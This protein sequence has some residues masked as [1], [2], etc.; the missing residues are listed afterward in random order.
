MVAEAEQSPA[1]ALMAHACNFLSLRQSEGDIDNGANCRGPYAGAG[2][3][4][5]LP[6]T[7]C[8]RIHDPGPSS[9]I[10][11]RNSTHL[12]I[13]RNLPGL[14]HPS[15]RA[16]LRTGEPSD[17]ACL[18]R[19]RSEAIERYL[20]WSKTSASNGF[21]GNHQRKESGRLLLRNRNQ[22]QQQAFCQKAASSFAER[23]GAVNL[24]KVVSG[25]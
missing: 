22:P 14:L 12:L 9:L 3:N 25:R 1:T 13:G 8:T 15:R 21:A 7:W 6:H 11:N 2:R 20:I 24:S 16:R 10:R 18:Q 23:R 19:N 4:Q 17:R 5:F